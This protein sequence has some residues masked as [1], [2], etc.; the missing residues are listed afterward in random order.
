M[1]P[2][3]TPE[4][5][6]SRRWEPASIANTVGQ[7]RGIYLLHGTGEHGKRYDEFATRLTEAG[8]LVAAH[9]H[10]GHGQSS[11]QRGLLRPANGLAHYAMPQIVRFADEVGAP[12]ILFGH[13]LGG[14]LAAE[15][16]LKYHVN[17]SAL[18]L[19]A[20]AFRPRISLLNRI[21]LNLL[22][23]VAPDKVIEL[24]HRPELLTRDECKQQAARQD[25]LIH[26]FKSA[27]LV[28]WMFDTGAESIKLASGLSVPALVL[29]AQQDP[30]VDPAAIRSWAAAA[31]PDLVTQY[32]YAEGLHE[33][34][35]EM[36]D[37]R[38]QITDD[39]LAW[40]AK[41][42]GQF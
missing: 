7:G 16:V 26:G 32:E 34:F 15:L 5:I 27:R 1:M 31:P 21:K 19:S 20:P 30:V 23:G 41:L 24:P 17:V 3:L 9:D 40:L 14:V 22:Y 18:V 10:V 36:P 37:V 8:W 2:E 4:T 28:R 38:A 12:P 25:E 42:A 11:G 33:L 39:T 6:F 29:I 13:S 35:N